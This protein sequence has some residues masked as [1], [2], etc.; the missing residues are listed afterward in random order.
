MEKVSI[1]GSSMPMNN[2]Q[3]LK[4]KGEGIEK[5]KFGPWMMVQ[6]KTKGTMFVSRKKKEL[7]TTNGKSAL[8]INKFEIICD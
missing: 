1:E 5:S 2:G 6:R 8:H 4:A 3:A 7:I